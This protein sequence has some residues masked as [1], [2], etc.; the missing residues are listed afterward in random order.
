MSP[1]EIGWRV[2]DL[3]HDQN[4]LQDLHYLARYLPRMVCSDGYA[5]YVL[6]MAPE[7]QCISQ[8]KWNWHC[9]NGRPLHDCGL[10][11][12]ANRGEWRLIYFLLHA[13]KWIPW[14]E[15]SV[16][17][18]GWSG[19]Q[20]CI[21]GGLF[22]QLLSSEARFPL[23]KFQTFHH[24]VAINITEVPQSEIFTEPLKYLDE[25]TQV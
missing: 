18:V 5:W 2:T 3:R 15:F 8:L 23:T 4:L 16:G 13:R 14:S 9:S 12:A 21:L 22:R 25:L 6:F 24:M 10:F 7:A 1:K 17:L 19:Q 11:D 20:S